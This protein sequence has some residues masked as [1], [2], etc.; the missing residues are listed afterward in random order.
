[1][2][3]AQVSDGSFG[4]KSMISYTCPPPAPTPDMGSFPHMKESLEATSLESGPWGRLWGRGR[5]VYD[6]HGRPIQK[7]CHGDRNLPFWSLQNPSVDGGDRAV[8]NGDRNHRVWVRD[9]RRICSVY[10]ASAFRIKAESQRTLNTH[11]FA[12]DNGNPL[13]VTV[14]YGKL[15][16]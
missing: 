13:C 16:T 15:F 6:H 5:V 2:L 3:V 7:A 9:L 4:R 8:T 11:T 12:P 1:M 14:H 10:S